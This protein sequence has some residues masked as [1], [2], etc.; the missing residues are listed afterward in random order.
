LAATEVFD[1][2]LYNCRLVYDNA[3]RGSN[4]V[5]GMTV[6][7]IR[8]FHMENGTI[9]PAEKQFAGLELPQRN[10]QDVAIE[11]VTMKVTNV[12]FGEYAAHWKLTG[13]QFWIHPDAS[14]AAGIATAGLDVEF[15][16]NAIHG[17]NL[18]AGGGSGALL[19]D[20]IGPG[21]YTAFVGQIRFHD[22]TIDCRADGNNCL[23]L[24]TRD[25]A[26]DRNRITAAGSTTG[27]K[28]EG[29]AAEFSIT[30][31]HIAMETQPALVLNVS[32][33]SGAVV[34]GNTLSGSGAYAMV[35]GGRPDRS[36][37]GRIAANN[38]I[39]GFAAPLHAVNDDPG[40][41]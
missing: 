16:Q 32:S 28:V 29:A 21:V 4:L 19:A 23:R 7:T 14:T 24:T 12:V 25:P 13:N 2:S 9:E 1:L 34:R 39:S 6:N 33:L 26:V 8:G 31:N 15:A 22:N 30:N 40:R 37:R 38:T 35:V 11:N 5:T 18:T 36:D 27:I 41:R 17:D 3:G 20:V 10:S